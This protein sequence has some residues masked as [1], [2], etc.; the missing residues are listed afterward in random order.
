MIRTE[1]IKA[2]ME[3]QGK[4]VQDVALEAG[5]TRPTVYDLL[6]ERRKPTLETIQAVCRALNIPLTKVI[7]EA[8]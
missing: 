1:I 7:A 5:V 3:K 6:D 8:A 2:A 4:S